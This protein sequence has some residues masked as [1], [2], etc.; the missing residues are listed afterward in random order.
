MASP[1][2]ELGFALSVANGAATAAM[3]ANSILNENVG[4]GMI[5]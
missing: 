3:A 2:Y 1:E 5:V 4:R